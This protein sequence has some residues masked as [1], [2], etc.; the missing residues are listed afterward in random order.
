MG[1]SVVKANVSTWMYG[2]QGRQGGDCMWLVL[3]CMICIRLDS[4]EAVARPRCS[5]ARWQG[6]VER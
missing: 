5:V 2:S 1:C 6:R 3:E 4:A